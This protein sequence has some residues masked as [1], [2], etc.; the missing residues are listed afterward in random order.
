MSKLIGIRSSGIDTHFIKSE[1]HFA[2]IRIESINDIIRTL[3]SSQRWAFT[4]F[5][6]GLVME[7]IVVSLKRVN[8]SV[9][10][11]VCFVLFSL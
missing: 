10:S 6:S 4:H 8:C 5:D 11:V 7:K 2:R 9:A 3:Y 1:H